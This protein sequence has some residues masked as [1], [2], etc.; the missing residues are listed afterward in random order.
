MRYIDNLRANNIPIYFYQIPPYPDIKENKE[1]N[2]AAKEAIGQKK[3]KKKNRNQKKWNSKYI[4]ERQVLGRVTATIKL[5][6]E[7]RTL[8]L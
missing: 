3:V 4:A 1:E 8:G 2:V 7:Q 5:A 6:L